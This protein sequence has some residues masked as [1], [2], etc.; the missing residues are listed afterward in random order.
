MKYNKAQKEIFEG[1]IRKY[2]VC[3]FFVDDEHFAVTANGYNAYVFPCCQIAF[4]IHKVKPYED[5]LRIKEVFKEE[6]KLKDTK[7]FRSL[8]GGKRLAKV[9]EGKNGK[10]FVDQALLT[11]FD[12][13]NYYQ[14][15]ANS[16]ILVE[17]FGEIVGCVLPMRIADEEKE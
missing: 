9:F 11:C 17:E 14:D 2:R 4:D 16:T 15:K 3:G 12:N 1:I 13:A 7:Y 8:Q 5:F 10:V 6:N